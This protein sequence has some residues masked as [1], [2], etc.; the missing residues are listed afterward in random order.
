MEG[1]VIIQEGFG[2]MTQKTKTERVILK[3]VLLGKK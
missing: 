2:S 1:F 3:V